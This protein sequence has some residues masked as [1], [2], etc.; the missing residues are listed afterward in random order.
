MMK[1]IV[2]RVYKGICSPR[3]AIR[4]VAHKCRSA[5]DGTISLPFLVLITGQ[6]CTLRCQDCG[7]FTPYLPQV[8][9]EVDAVCDDFRRLSQVARVGSLQIQ[10]GEALI[11]PG[12]VR[13]LKCVQSASSSITIATNGTR[14]LSPEQI[15]VIKAVG[16]NIRISDYQISQQRSS[17]LEEQ[18]KAHGIRSR[19]YRFAGGQGNWTDL[20]GKH[21]ERND[22]NETR[23]IYETCPFNGCLTLENGIIA[24]CSRAT[25]SHHMQSFIPN[26][27][28][29]VAVRAIQPTQLRHKLAN[30]IRHPIAM[31][32]C[33]Y[34]RGNKGHQ[35]P[36]AIQI[37]RTHPN[38]AIDGDKK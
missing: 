31:E 6:K 28:D 24:R 22:D 15:E 14:L 34:C 9:Y 29:F 7:N 36:P 11:Y 3:M 2:K 25:V 27:A 33:R 13:L 21:M 1:H 23:E 5:L 20:G 17:E 30:Y 4:Y 19:L 37:K 38:K 35:I 10:G 32:A 8:H 12:L 16:A 26:E 18:C